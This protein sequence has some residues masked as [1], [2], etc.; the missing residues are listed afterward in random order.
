[1][2]RVPTYA[3]FNGIRYQYVG[4]RYTKKSADALAKMLRK[5]GWNVKVEV[6]KFPKMGT[7]LYEV[8]KSHGERPPKLYIQGR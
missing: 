4:E 6:T 8:Y 2:P 1:M 3:T 7:A 5:N